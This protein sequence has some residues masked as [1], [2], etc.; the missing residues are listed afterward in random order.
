MIATSNEV[1]YSSMKIIDDVN[2]ED[3][4]LVGNT[5]SDSDIVEYL[6]LLDAFII[7]PPVEMISSSRSIF[8]SP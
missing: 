6:L 1:K 8:L 4:L 7:V 5:R 3:V 2:G